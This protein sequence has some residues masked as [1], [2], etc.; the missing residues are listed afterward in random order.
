MKWGGEF[1]KLLAFS[2]KV[3]LYLIILGTVSK[4]K[5]LYPKQKSTRGGVWLQEVELSQILDL[6]KNHLWRVAHVPGGEGG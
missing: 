4:E 5:L 6:A 2:L 3:V 1:K